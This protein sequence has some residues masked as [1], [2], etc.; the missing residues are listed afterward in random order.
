LRDA[1]SDLTGKQS[2]YRPG[3]QCASAKDAAGS[4]QSV[5]HKPSHVCNTTAGKAIDHLI[6]VARQW[7]YV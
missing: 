6:E 1:K 3:D 2:M 5:T 4:A 7:H